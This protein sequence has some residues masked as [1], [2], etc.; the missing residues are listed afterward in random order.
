MNTKETGRKLSRICHGPKA[1]W[2]GLPVVKKLAQE[3][4]VL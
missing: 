4:G 3:A 2:K 1:F